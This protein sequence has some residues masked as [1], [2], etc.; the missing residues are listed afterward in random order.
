MTRLGSEGFWLGDYGGGRLVGR[1]FGARRSSP[2]RGAGARGRHSPAPWTVVP[3]K[4]LSLSLS[5][6]LSLRPGRQASQ[7]LSALFGTPT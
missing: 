4:A 6:S 3:N 2:V 1:A 7:P 5:L